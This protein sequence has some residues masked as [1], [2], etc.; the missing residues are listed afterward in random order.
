MK[1]LPYRLVAVE[2][3]DSYGCGA[4]WEE[5]PDRPPPAHRCYSVGWLVAKTE[6]VV[7]I[8]PHI[9]PEN[10]DIGGP[11]QGCGDMTIPRCAVRKIINLEVKA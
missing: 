11:E 8:V 3:L 9:S 5:M 2:W 4:I 6:D 1:E 10:K 7:V